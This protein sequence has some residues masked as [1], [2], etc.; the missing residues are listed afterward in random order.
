MTNTK[1]DIKILKN[2]KK[3]LPLLRAPQKPTLIGLR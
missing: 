3:L 1:N 2:W